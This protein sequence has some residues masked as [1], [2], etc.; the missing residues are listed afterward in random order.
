MFGFNYLS[1]TTRGTQD[2]GDH[3]SRPVSR[4]DRADGA[5]WAHPLRHLA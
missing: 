4:G 2:N 3:A 1:I 5:P